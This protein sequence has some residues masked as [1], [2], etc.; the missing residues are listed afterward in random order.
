[1]TNGKPAPQ[2]PVAVDA[3]TRCA[4]TLFRNLKERGNRYAAVKVDGP[5]NWC[6]TEPRAE[7]ALLDA[8]ETD[9]HAIIERLAS[10]LEPF[11]TTDNPEAAFVIVRDALK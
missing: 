7:Q 9:E 4:L 11:L 3:E 1:M 8:L 5:L 2:E 6:I 10:K